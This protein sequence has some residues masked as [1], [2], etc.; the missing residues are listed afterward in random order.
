MESYHVRTGVF[1]INSTSYK[2]TFNFSREIRRYIKVR[3]IL[4]HMMKESCIVYFP[5]MIYN[6]VQNENSKY[7][8]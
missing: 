3:V 5:N 2:K 8:K 6:A 7:Y 4:A 1:C